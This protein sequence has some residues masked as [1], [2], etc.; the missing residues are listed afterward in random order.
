[1]KR[2]VSFLLII[3]IVSITNFSCMSMLVPKAAKKEQL[4]LQKIYT[5][6]GYNKNKIYNRSIEWI[7]KTFIPIKDVIQTNDTNGGE[8]VLIG[9]TKMKFKYSGVQTAGIVYYVMKI[10][11]K[12]EKIRITYNDYHSISDNT[13]KPVIYETIAVQINNQLEELSENYLAFIKNGKI[14]EDW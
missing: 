12:N 11:I 9:N 1:M 5:L 14:K 8:I 13:K 3:F 4:Q 10:D 7:K 6:P 2:K